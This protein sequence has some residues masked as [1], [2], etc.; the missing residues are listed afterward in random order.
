MQIPTPKFL[1]KKNRWISFSGTLKR[2]M[3]HNSFLMGSKG[4][5]GS[6]SGPS[7]T[8]YSEEPENLLKIPRIHFKNNSRP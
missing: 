4:S 2:K 6:E 1:G 7:L 8:N 5:E 3:C